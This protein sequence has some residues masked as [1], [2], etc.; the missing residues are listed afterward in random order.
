MII[1]LLAPQVQSLLVCVWLSAVAA[2]AS[3]D[4]RHI[5]NVCVHNK[6]THC[7][8]LFSSRANACFDNW[9]RVARCRLRLPRRNG[10]ERP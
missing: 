5:I 3:G 6:R 2:G 8:L 7:L 10:A 9:R 4:G 1:S